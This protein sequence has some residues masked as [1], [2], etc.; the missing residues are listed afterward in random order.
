VSGQDFSRA[1]K[2]FIFG[3][4]ERASAREGSA[5]PTFSA[6]RSSGM[7][8]ITHSQ[9]FLHGVAAANADNPFVF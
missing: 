1:V 3:H 6:A 4:S 8:K 5:V 7:V 9:Q 2:P